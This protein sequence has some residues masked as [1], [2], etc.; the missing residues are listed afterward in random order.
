MSLT[1]NW[2]GI[3]CNILNNN[4]I[5]NN[6]EVNWPAIRFNNNKDYNKS[7]YAR[8]NYHGATNQSMAM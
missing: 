6:T 8:L 1:H 5:N 3:R 2:P 4:K 7:L